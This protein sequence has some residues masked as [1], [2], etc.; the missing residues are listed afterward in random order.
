MIIKTKA[1]RY[2]LFIHGEGNFRREIDSSYKSHRV[3]DKPIYF[4]LIRQYLID[5]WSAEI[6]NEIE[7]DDKVAILQN[8]GSIISST[9]KDLLQIPG[10]HYNYR[11]CKT[12]EITEQVGWMNL[13]IQILTGDVADNVKGLYKIG[14][15]KATVL[16]KDCKT[17]DELFKTVRGKYKEVI[18]EGWEKELDITSRLLYLWRVENDP[19]RFPI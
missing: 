3:N 8:D 14:I 2:R 19:W 1:D 17:K 16:L 6:V 10:K 4:E 18:G 7:V 11:T 12:T 13:C 15:K 5:T 9:D